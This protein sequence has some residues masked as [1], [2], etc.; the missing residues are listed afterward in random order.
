MIYKQIIIVQNSE[1]YKLRFSRRF[2]HIEHMIVVVFED[3]RFSAF[4]MSPRRCHA[5]LKEFVCFIVIL[6]N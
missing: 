6:E 3:E 2:R 5:V 4:Y 1:V